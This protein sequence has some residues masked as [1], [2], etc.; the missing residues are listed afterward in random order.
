MSLS[1]KLGVTYVKRHEIFIL[2]EQN[3]T[4]MY[5][6]KITIGN[7][8]FGY[9]GSPATK[10]H[11]SEPTGLCF[12]FDSAIFCCFGGSK[13]GYIKIHTPVEFACTFMSK[14]REIYHAIGFLPKKDPNRLAQTGVRPAF[15]F[16]ESTEIVIDSLAYM[17]SLTAQRKDYLKITTAGPEGTVYHA[18]VNDFA[19]T[20]KGLE[21]HTQSLKQADLHDV[22]DK[23]NFY[24]FVNESR[25]EHGFVK[26]KQN[27]QYRHPS[28]QQ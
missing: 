5:N 27:G 11:L 9:S 20:V 15:P 18:S 14:V 10:A 12:D 26:H 24:V 28:L 25:K 7:G 23:F 4:C 22:V 21:E 19:E 1:G 13:N 17:E 16:V 3:G 8:I 2:K 6:I